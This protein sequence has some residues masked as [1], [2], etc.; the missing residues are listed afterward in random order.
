M[1]LLALVIPLILFGVLLYLVDQVLPID[2]SVKTIIR[3][4]VIV[5]ILVWLVRVLLGVSLPIRW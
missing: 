2:P 5:A 3:V 1:E 4:V